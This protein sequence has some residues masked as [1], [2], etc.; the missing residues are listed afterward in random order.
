MGKPGKGGRPAKPTSLKVL[1]GDR[2]DRINRDEPLPERGDVA[3]P[4]WLDDR[5]RQVWDRLA[6][7]LTAKG[8]LTSWD[9]DAFAAFCTVVVRNADALSDVACN[10]TSLTTVER[11]LS[12][13]TVIYRVVK[14]PAWQVARESTALVATLG[15]RFGLN[16]SDRS[17]IKV[18]GDR[19]ATQG[20]ERLLG[21]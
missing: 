16:P 13:G 21:G 9:V 11:E 8:V 17:Q 18:G 7:D 12:D 6:P 4:E 10:G 1:H 20:A 2:E 3:A 19:G 14:N 5:S 15:G